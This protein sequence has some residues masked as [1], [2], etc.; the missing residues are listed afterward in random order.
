MEGLLGRTITD[1]GEL[2]RALTLT[3]SVNEAGKILLYL[4][5]P[6]L[7]L[8]LKESVRAT[9]LAASMAQQSA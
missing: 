4:L 3:L 1:T 5:R 7:G 8:T 6:L 2:Y 9:H